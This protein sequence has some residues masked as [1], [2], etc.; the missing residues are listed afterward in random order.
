MRK[1]TF[2]YLLITLSLYLG[3]IIITII[4][5]IKD[6]LSNALSLSLIIIDSILSLYIIYRLFYIKRIYFI[7]LIFKY[8]AVGFNFAMFWVIISVVLD[9]DDNNSRFK[10]DNEKLTPYKARIYL[11]KELFI[12]LKF[13]LHMISRIRYSRDSINKTKGCITDEKKHWLYMGIE[14]EN[15][16]LNY[17]KYIKNKEYEELKNKNIILRE[18]N[19]RLKEDKK[20]INNNVLRRQKMEIIREYIKSN[21]QIK[22]SSNSLLK[23][24][25]IEIKHKCNGLTINQK[26]YEEIIINYIK[27]R[28]TSYLLCP[29]TNQLFSDPYITPDGQT[30]EKETILNQIEKKG[31]NP[32]NNNRLYS[33]ELIEN[34]LVSDICKLLKIGSDFNLNNFIEIKKL[35]LDTGTKKLYE[36]PCVISRG[37]IKGLTEEKFNFENSKRYPNLV[38]KNIISQNLEIFEDDFLKLDV[39][40]GEQNIPMP[41]EK[42]NNDDSHIYINNQ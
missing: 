15:R 13:Y 2:I 3:S 10:K 23:K 19:K 34:K 41:N 38:I 1:S 27:Q 12:I 25:L 35:L 14:E 26:K 6:L 8:L 17:E 21:N 11:L 29:I 30:F 16:D 4:M 28:I 33:D 5:L 31:V 37:I 40:Q 39:E 42:M 7:S 20:R 24:L 9:Y 36:F 18:E 32:I 22:I